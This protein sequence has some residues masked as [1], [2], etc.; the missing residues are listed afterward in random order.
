MPKKRVGFFIA[1]Y[2]EQTFD[3]AFLS[4]EA[5]TKQLHGVQNGKPMKAIFARWLVVL[6]LA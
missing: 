4:A 1:T 3:W 5:L 6:Y 2:E